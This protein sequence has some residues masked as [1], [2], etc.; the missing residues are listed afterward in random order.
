MN[1]FSLEGRVAL[2]TGASRGLG[3]AMARALAENGAKVIANARNADELAAAAAKIGAVPLAFDVTDAKAARAALE[4]VAAQHGKLDILV[5]NA[6]IQHRRPITDWE[7]A[8]FDRVISVNLSS[9]FRLARDAVR[10]MLP[11][12]HG[13]IINTG[14]IAG[15]LARPTIHA[16]VA[17]KAGLHGLTRSMAAELGRTGITVNAIAPGYFATEMNTALLDDKVFNAWVEGRTPA[18]RWA[19]PEE[20]GGAVVFLASDAAAYVNG[21]VLAVDGGLSVTM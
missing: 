9:C 15:I 5:N 4:G 11:N 12:R 3:F 13:R 21:H 7:D 8:D 20:L 1:P 19:R 2:V 10:L 17:A 16:Y 18:G 14:S 6:G